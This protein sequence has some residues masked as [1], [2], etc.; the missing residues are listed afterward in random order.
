MPY[1]FHCLILAV[2]V[3]NHDIECLMLYVPERQ[4][5]PY[6][7]ALCASRYWVPRVETQTA[8]ACSNIDILGFNTV[9]TGFK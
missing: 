2:C 5:Q 4:N 1:L 7:D 9:F 8:T 6:W 3:E